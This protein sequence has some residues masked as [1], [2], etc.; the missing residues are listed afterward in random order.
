MPSPFYIPTYRLEYS[1]GLLLL[2]TKF[3]ENPGTKYFDEYGKVVI[4]LDGSN[5]Y[6]KTI[7]YAEEFQNGEAKVYFMGQDNMFY[8]VKI[9]KKGAW[10]TKPTQILESKVPRYY[11]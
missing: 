6:Y 7:E 3:G 4:S 9:D 10:I 8:Y 1:E 11:F 5:K 2:H